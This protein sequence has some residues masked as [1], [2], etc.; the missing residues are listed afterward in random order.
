MP[1]VRRMCEDELEAAGKLILPLPTDA[2]EEISQA[3]Y[4]KIRGDKLFDIVR[5]TR[6]DGFVFLEVKVRSKY[7]PKNFFGYEWYRMKE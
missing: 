6:K 5:T 1:Q 7:D 2:Y 4:D 3:Y